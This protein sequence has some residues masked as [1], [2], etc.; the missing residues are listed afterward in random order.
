M[1][2]LKNKLSIDVDD[3]IGLG[4]LGGIRIEGKPILCAFFEPAAPG[5]GDCP[6][7]DVK[8][9]Q[10][11]RGFGGGRI[12]GLR[13]V[14]HNWPAFKDMD[15]D[16]AAKVCSDY[17]TKVELEAKARIVDAVEWDVE[18]HSLQWAKEFLVGKSEAEGGPTK[19]IRGAGGFL[20]D[21][22]RAWTLGYRWGRPGVFTTEGRQDTT[23]AQAALAVEAGLL[24]GP[25]CYN[26]AMSEAWDLWFELQTWVLNANP[27]RPNGAR[28]PITSVLPYYDAKKELFPKG[29]QETVLF[30]SSRLSV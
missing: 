12:S 16:Q 30:A 29:A 15:G 17:I 8:T 2:V 14:P 11:W 28:V 19:G 10:T 23:T 7:G 24:F 4:N 26:G 9:L 18:T 22:V 20:P 1:H 5:M 6:R 13:F 27:Q 25:Q 3:Q 21:P